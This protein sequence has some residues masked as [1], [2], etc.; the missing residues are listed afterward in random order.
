MV[1]KLF[2]GFLALILVFIVL[3]FCK[4]QFIGKK[5]DAAAFEPYL[6][7]QPAYTHP[8]RLTYLGTSCFIIGY[9]DKQIILDP[10]FS[11]PNLLSSA[12]GKL[13]YPNLSDRIDSNLYNHVSMITI[14][15]GHYDHCLDIRNFLR[16]NNNL[17]IAADPGILNELTSVFQNKAIQQ[18]PIVKNSKKEWIYSPDS[19]F[20]VFA[21]P[22]THS[23]HFDH[24]TLFTGSYEQPLPS[25]PGKL[26]DWKLC[27][28]NSYLVDL[29]DNGV[30]T[31][32][33]LM[34]TG[35]MN[36]DGKADLQKLS[37]ERKTD[38]LLHIF[39]KKE[40]CWDNLN[41]MYL[42]ARPGLVLLHHWN[43]FFR[44]NDKPL[45]YLRSSELPEVLE[46]LNNN[47]IP[48]KIM[49]PFSTVDL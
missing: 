45:Q 49:P 9:K 21:L 3:V 22:S 24:V 48:V 1:K 28:C 32:R 30:V 12:F 19:S 37:K 4:L 46:E 16:A 7:K 25:L 40:Q 2:K 34:C 18:D 15:H 38:L 23:P 43:N 14:S 35:N 44:S 29:L 26:W 13:K 20:R 33:V 42:I 36:P 6:L 10:F 17:T 5:F 8:I 41:E 27:E 11:N 39:W 47:G 31:Y